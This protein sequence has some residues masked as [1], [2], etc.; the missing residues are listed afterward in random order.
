[1]KLLTQFWDFFSSV[2]LA[3][4]TLCALAATSIIGTIIPQGESSAF[5]V[6]NFGE[7]TAHF[8]QVLDIANMY[9][10][11]W[12]LGLLGILSTN[13]IICSLDRFPLVWKAITADNLAIAPERIEKMANCSKWQFA[14]D[15]I[16]QIDLPGLL[17]QNGWKA[18]SKKLGNDELFFSQK[19]RWSRVGV[20]IVHSSIL[21]IFAGA[22]IGHF[23]GFKGSVMIPETSSTQKVFAYKNAD[24]IDLGFEVRCNSFAVQFYDNG[25]PKEYKSSLT[26]L[27]NG[28]E[29]LTR[30]IVVNS[31][32]TYRGITF[33]QSSYQGYQDF[34]VNITDN[35]SGE[36]KQFTIPFQKQMTWEEKGLQF[37]I[38][39][40]EAVGQRVTRAKLWFKARENPAAI[41]WLKDNETITVTSGAKEYT[42]SAKQMYATGLQVAK[43]PGVWVVYIGCGIML[44]G[45]YLAF[46]MSHRRI[47][48]YKKNGSSNNPQLWLAGS[49]NKNKMA[50]AQVFGELKTHIEHAVQR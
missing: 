10:S 14:T 45:L 16:D 37:G 38:V 18:D 13:L 15:K 2:K 49:T 6:K 47:W 7:K 11:W 24:S 20:Y 46:F 41:E 3:I 29:V 50:F 48:L 22:V 8:F 17:G 36:V 40:A 28:R 39:N 1:M 44:L 30:D 42:V 12:F 23:F 21:I 5:Y 43:D 4:F 33:Y 31:P 19:G 25:V 26:V 34:I 9:Y 32:L 35:S 27:E